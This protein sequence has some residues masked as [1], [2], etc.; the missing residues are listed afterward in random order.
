MDQSQPQQIVDQTA[1]PTPPGYKQESPVQEITRAEKKDSKKTLYT[2]SYVSIIIKN[3]LAG[4]FRA[5]GT[6]I[7]YIIFLLIMV[8]VFKTYIMPEIQPLLD[9]VD[10]LGTLQES[11][12][13][14]ETEN[15]ITIDPETVNQIMEQFKQ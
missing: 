9:T 3:F 11:L 14:P 6:V 4:F 1:P 2:S 10:Q 13:A 7:V 8:H 12:T 15:P 5:L